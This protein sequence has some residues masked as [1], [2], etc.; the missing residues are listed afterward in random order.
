MKIERTYHVEVQTIDA[1][2]RVIFNSQVNVFLDPK[3]KVSG[4]RKVVFPQLV[5]SHLEHKYSGSVSFLA[6]VLLL[7]PNHRKIK[8]GTDLQSP[9]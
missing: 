7:L 4:V 8:V 3:A 9:I 2:A 5:F 1:N 6:R